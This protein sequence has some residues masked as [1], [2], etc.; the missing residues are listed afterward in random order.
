MSYRVYDKKRKKFIKDNVYLTPDGELV[1]SKKSIFGNR[2]SFV[3]QDRYVYQK[4]I[5][6]NDKNN[7]PIYIGDYLEAKV[8]DDRI[9]TGL[10]TY[11]DELS[12]YI[13]L[14]FET[15][16]FFTL[17]TQVCEY[18]KIVGNV[19]DEDKKRK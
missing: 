9:V 2:L 15:D 4:A 16:E 12:S 7:A 13:I 8:D 19:F 1:E 18:I 6:L 3:D 14:C 5:E 17:G 11:A 10:V